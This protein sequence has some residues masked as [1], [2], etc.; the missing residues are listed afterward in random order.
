MAIPNLQPDT[1]QSTRASQ[2]GQVWGSVIQNITNSVSNAIGQYAEHQK[3]INSPEYKLAQSK[4]DD[5]KAEEF[6]VE[7]LKDTISKRATNYRMAD[8]K[9]TTG[10]NLIPKHGQPE[11]EE[12]AEPVS[13]PVQ[14]PELEPVGRGPQQ[15]LNQPQ[16]E[17]VQQD[18][19]EDDITKSIS[20]TTAPDQSL[21]SPQDL[22]QGQS[23][24]PP[25]DLGLPKQGAETPQLD[26]V[27]RTD[28]PIAQ[29]QEIKLPEKEVL[30]QEPI[31]F[32]PEEYQ[33]SF[34]KKLDGMSKQELL[35]YMDNLDNYQQLKLKHRSV[36]G[37]KAYPFNKMDDEANFRT[38][39][40]VTNIA[41]DVDKWETDKG[42]EFIDFMHKK[43]T[44]EVPK[45]TEDSGTFQHFKSWAMDRFGANADMPD[46]PQSGIE[47]G[48][49][50]LIFD[51]KHNPELSTM[52]K[53]KFGFSQKM[54]PQQKADLSIETAK[55]K[56]KIEAKKSM[57]VFMKKGQVR[58]EVAKNDATIKEW[59]E[60]S[61]RLFKQQQLMRN[62]ETEVSDTKVGSKEK[63]ETTKRQVEGLKE[64][65]KDEILAQKIYNNGA[66]QGM[67]PQQAQSLANKIA[68]FDSAEDWE[69]LRK[70]RPDDYKALQNT[71]R[72]TG[73]TIIPRAEDTYE[74]LVQTLKT[75]KFGNLG[76]FPDLAG[77]GTQDE[78][79]NLTAMS[80]SQVSALVGE[81]KVPFH[82]YVTIF[83]KGREVTVSV[84][85][86]R[87]KLEQAAQR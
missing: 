67:K 62:A 31:E 86:I 21:A 50:L 23:I 25:Q 11:V 55:E 54:T 45:G 36:F 51:E 6:N 1:S 40:W 70:A 63:F 37:P 13:T 81:P 74:D 82:T 5:K 18:I 3:K 9:F 12:G 85:M 28:V 73:E 17:P 78:P 72:A 87:K 30:S 22:G 58:E 35:V 59:E 19:P 57:A 80:G 33:Q 15:S 4:L 20:R 84:G 24:A 69:K 42:Q 38:P 10:K 39:A 68:S 60:S 71:E 75:Q 49:M 44:E 41:D 64:E 79:L 76:P 8:L 2:E 83:N 52:M 46:D 53:D 26:P 27:S 16:L 77:K 34:R 14:Q 7:K 61:D 29:S 32:N 56:A 47:K 66:Y 65:F 48:K 43:Y